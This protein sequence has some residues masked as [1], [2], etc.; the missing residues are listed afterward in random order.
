MTP[1]PWSFS[2]LTSF[3]TCPRQYYEMRI[4]KSFQEE[5]G[6][7]AAWGERL[8]KHI[9]DY[10][11]GEE[12]HADLALYSPQIL[13][14]LDGIGGIE[15]T[16]TVFVAA[17]HEVALNRNIEPT[18]FFAEDTWARG[19][20]DVLR[21]EGSKAWVIDWKS[22]KVK[23]DSRQLMLFALFVFY[24]FPK[25]EVV[26]TSFE[27]LKFNQSTTAVFLRRDIDL[28]WSKFLPDLNA[29][30]QAFNNDTWQARPS[31]LCRNFCAVLSCQHCGRV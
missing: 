16:E 4:A 23:P 8:H 15:I 30:V 21:V 22:G 18:E 2:S 19:I 3:N 9:E 14:A 26:Y 24:H 28:I 11:N 31:G 12:M 17:E 20:L 7:A 13:K 10:I 6:E 29:Y 25:V 5:Q 27:W 1:K